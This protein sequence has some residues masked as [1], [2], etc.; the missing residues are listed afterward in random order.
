MIATFLIEMALALY[1]LSTRRMNL[2]V[3]LGV[4]LLV[5]LATF[6]LA[7]YSICESFGFHPDIWAKIGF[8]AITLLPP[9]GVHLVY[10]IA[11]KRN[12]HLV[13]G[14]Y[15]AAAIWIAIFVFGPVMK[16]S[17]CD[18]NYVIFHITEPAE[19]LYYIYYNILMVVPMIQGVRFARKSRSKRKKSA[20]YLLVAGYASF[21]L[22][23]IVFA[24]LV[25]GTSGGRMPSIL[26]GFAVI[27]AVILAVG[28]LPH[29]S[30]KKKRR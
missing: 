21:I 16:G 30:R 17:V 14:S 9:L 6:Q 26:C 13:Y 19:T 22:P 29:A 20:L 28:V 8:T 4:V 25:D 7:E 18:G 11:K 27:M 12:T 1:V 24:K 23:S 5:C 10:T 15:L 3:K 2:A